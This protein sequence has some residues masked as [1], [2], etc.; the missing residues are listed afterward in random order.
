M[1]DIPAFEEFSKIPRLPRECIVTEKIDGT[2]G[3]VLVLEDGR[4]V[5]GRVIVLFGRPPG[6]DYQ[7]WAEKYPTCADLVG[8]VIKG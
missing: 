8:S 6:I 1:S 2:N 5:A 4:V 7:S 3:T